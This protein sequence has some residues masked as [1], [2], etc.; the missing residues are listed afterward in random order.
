MVGGTIPSNPLNLMGWFPRDFGLGLGGGA[1]GKG[2]NGFG[3]SIFAV[4]T[5]P[6]PGVA[7]FLKELGLFSTYAV[8]SQ[9]PNSL[10]GPAGYGSVNYVAANTIFP[11][12]I[13]F[14]N[15]PTATAPA[16][17]VDITDQLDPNLDWSTFQ[18]T[19]GRL[20]RH[21]PRHP[22]GQPVLRDHR[23]D[24]VQRRDVRRRDRAQP[25]PGHGQCSP[26]R[27]SRSTPT[28]TCRPDVL[29]GFLPPEDGTGRGMGYVSFIIEPKS[30][31]PT[32]T[33]DPQRRPDHL[34]RQPGIATDQVDDDD[35]SQGVD[36]TKQAL[37]TIDAG[38]PTSSVGPLP[39][40][41]TSASLHRDLVGPG[42]P[43]RLG[44]RLLQHLRLRRRRAVH[45]LAVGHD[46]RPRR[47][48]PA[49]SATPTAS[50]ASPPTTSATS[51]RLPTSAQ[52]TT[53]SSLP[54]TLTSIAPVSPNPRNTPVSS[55]DV[56]FSEPINLNQLHGRRPDPDRQRRS[57]P[58]HRRRLH[59]PGLRLDLPNRR[60]VRPDL[61]RGDLHAD[62]QRRRHPG[63]VRQPG[64]RLA[65][66][67][68][69]DGH[70]PAD[71]HGQRL[72]A[73]TTSTSF[74]SRSPAPTRPER[75]AARPRASPRIAIYDS[76]DGGPFTLVRDRHARQ[77]LGAFTGQ[78]GH[79]YGFYSV[80][81]DNAGNV[82]PTPTAAQQ[83]V[84]ILSP[85]TVTSIAAVSPNPRNTPVSTIDVTLS[86]PAAAGSFY[87][88]RLDPHR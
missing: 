70:D 24:D 75:T 69:A 27:S 16:Q 74:L 88:H 21:D 87:Q 49:Q 50:T 13:D 43:R 81:T 79:T 72:P 58:D 18:L 5:F 25:E 3:G 19:G 57:Q 54:L 37:V 77:S 4:N 17:R 82:Q 53:R 30:G 31:L 47:P 34:R 29:T 40:T 33:P 14:E 56:T 71:Q 2:A 52:A 63:P 76:T 78:A 68:L 84:Q 35:P 46:R 9:D 41:E 85:L 59:Q 38:P 66:D 39:A 83:T 28:P 32:G 12:Q 51:R 8:T 36:P 1:G 62:R 67:L 26:P 48:S 86:L 65:V 73:Q 60:P 11:Y 80:A 42:R 20:R 15:A 64:H 23:A 61:R 10:T 44:H 45:A 7:N 6:L 22:G 55:I